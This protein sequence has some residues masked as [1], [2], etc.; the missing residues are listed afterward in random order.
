MSSGAGLLS[1]QTSECSTSQQVDVYFSSDDDALEETNTTN[2]LPVPASQNQSTRQDAYHILCLLPVV[3]VK[4]YRYV[5]ELTVRCR[6]R[7]SL[8]N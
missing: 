6:Y 5:S 3:D 4:T 1:D 8:L 2:Q 7:T